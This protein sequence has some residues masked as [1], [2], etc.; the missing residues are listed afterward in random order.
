MSVEEKFYLLV[1]DEVRSQPGLAESL[2]FD[3]EGYAQGFA[4][5]S[6]D[7]ALERLDDWKPGDGARGFG[8]TSTLTPPPPELT[9]EL[10]TL[11]GRLTLDLQED[12]QLLCRQALLNLLWWQPR[13]AEERINLAKYLR[14]EWAFAHFVYG[15]LR[16]VSGN[17]GRAHFELYLALNR[18]PL[19][20]ARA[21]VERALDLVR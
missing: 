3:L 21:R 12:Y 19:V 16:G 4:G 11:R 8:I 15:L 20:C 5:C 17:L 2:P 9:D 18:E 6:L 10:D 13:G 7:E 1:M 14:D